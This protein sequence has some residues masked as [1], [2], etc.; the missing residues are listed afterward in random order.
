MHWLAGKVAGAN[1]E[2]SKTTF[3][4]GDSPHVSKIPVMVAEEKV[5][6]VTQ[7]SSPGDAAASGQQLPTI[8]WKKMAI[9]ELQKVSHQL[10]LTVNSFAPVDNQ[11]SGLS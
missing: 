3:D 9:A 1:W 7:C 6:D 4:D 8:K 11:L 10:L 2:G 5:A